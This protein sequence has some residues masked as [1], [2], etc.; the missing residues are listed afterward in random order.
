MNRLL[1]PLLT[2]GILPPTT[3]ASAEP[4][5]QRIARAGS[6]ASL[7]GPAE[8]FTGRVR[9]DPPYGATD[10]IPASG[11]WVTFEPGAR[12]AWHTH[13]RGQY[14]V[15]TAGVGRTQQWGGPIEELK[16]GDVVW[17]APGIKHWHGAAPTTA[18]THLAVTGR[19]EQG[20]NVTWMEKVSDA[21]YQAK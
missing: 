19:D 4:A 7:A 10:E 21:Q 17:C 13:P 11:A 18:M 1:L 2:L 9:V 20:Q 12:S 5:G 14:L 6:Q 3:E 16:P 15:V 8:N